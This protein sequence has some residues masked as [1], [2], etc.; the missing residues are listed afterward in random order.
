VGTTEENGVMSR[1]PDCA[2]VRSYVLNNLEDGPVRVADLIRFGA[3]E[4]G[5]TYREIQAAGEHFGVIAQELDGELY[6][7]RPANLF[8]IWWGNRSAH[9][10]ERHG[11]HAAMLDGGTAV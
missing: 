9:Y 7:M 2:W 6:W 8:A 3:T 1:V 10:G 11:E 4:F 5:F